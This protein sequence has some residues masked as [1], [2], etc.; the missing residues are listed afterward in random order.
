[1]GSLLATAAT[2]QVPQCTVPNTLVN[3]QVADAT[4]V[5]EN[6]NAVANCV[7]SARGDTV[8]HEGTPATGEI[9]VFAS[10]TGITGGN[11]TGD[12]TTSGS[13]AT[14]LAASGVTPGTYYNATVTVDAKGRVTFVE[15]GPLGAGSG[16]LAFTTLF[17]EPAYTLPAGTSTIIDV[18]TANE[19]MIIGHLIT[20]SASGTINIQFSVDGGATWV[21]TNVYLVDISTAGAV[22]G[23]NPAIITSSSTSLARSFSLH[24]PNLKSATPKPFFGNRSGFFNNPAPITHVRIYTTAGNITGGS[25]TV[26]GR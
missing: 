7:D 24:V 5:M 15:S 4:D 25:L 26:L 13:T 10:P 19:V 18:S 16:T 14:E 2:A 6:F 11:L 20:K 17:N 3:G 23:S 8:T 9:A 12:V 22:G 1:M 21:S